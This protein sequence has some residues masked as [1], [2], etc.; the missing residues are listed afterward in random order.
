M[1]LWKG[2]RVSVAKHQPAA[3]YRSRRAGFTLVETVMALAIFGVS[4]YI[5]ISLFNISLGYSASSRNHGV[6]AALAEE[7]LH[8]IQSNPGAYQWPSGSEFLAGERM[9]V[10]PQGEAG[11]HGLPVEA[12]SALPVDTRARTREEL[13]YKRFSWQAQARLPEENSSHVELT[14]VIEWYDAG[15]PQSLA[16]TS[17]VARDVLEAS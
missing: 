6:A 16:L 1:R 4:T 14:V 13:L 8:A 7:H 9:Q 2:E 3:A 11:E 12:P 5:I 17:A 15:N 10:R